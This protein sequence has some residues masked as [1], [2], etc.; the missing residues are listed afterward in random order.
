MVENK[1]IDTLVVLEN[2]LYRRASEDS[3]NELFKRSRQVIVLDHLVN[4]TTSN[5][6]IVFPAATFAESEGTLVNN[7]GRAQRY[8]KAIDP[9]TQVQESWRWIAEFIKVRD[10]KS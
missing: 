8:Y 6:D 1:E 10:G 4:R 2:D 5:A 3:V 7:E 9:E